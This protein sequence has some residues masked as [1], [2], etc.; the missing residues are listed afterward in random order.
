MCRSRAW[1]SQATVGSKWTLEPGY[2][3]WADAQGILSQVT[4]R[5]TRSSARARIA[6]TLPTATPTVTRSCTRSSDRARIA[7]WQPNEGFRPSNTSSSTSLC[8]FRNLFLGKSPTADQRNLRDVQLLGGDIH[9]AAP[10]RRWRM[11]YRV[12]PGSARIEGK[13]EPSQRPCFTPR[14]CTSPILGSQVLRQRREE[15]IPMFVSGGSRLRIQ[16]SA[17]RLDRFP[18]VLLQEL[19]DQT[20]PSRLVGPNEQGA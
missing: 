14:R 5:C 6:T 8:P 7:T 19:R 18:P 10:K 4:N 11:H 12:H 2:G 1:G 16:K 13:P 9:A 3:S 20:P 15:D 17:T